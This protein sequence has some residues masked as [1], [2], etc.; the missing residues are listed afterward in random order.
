MADA[1]PPKNIYLQW[2]GDSD[3]PERDGEP[4]GVTWSRV[5]VHED[6]V[7]YLRKDRCVPIDRHRAM[8]EQAGHFQTEL[9]KVAAMQ[10]G[11]IRIPDHEARNMDIDDRYMLCF[12]DKE[13]QETVI[14]LSE[15]EEG[16]DDDN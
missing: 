12:R 16:D 9:M 7:A 15:P 3:E 11:E 14:R 5:Q 8:I 13:T 4:E 2:Q 10:G 6:D 1:E